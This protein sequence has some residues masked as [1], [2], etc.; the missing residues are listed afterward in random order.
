MPRK[1]LV[2]RVIALA[3]AVAGVLAG[4]A[5]ERPPIN[6][7]QANALA[8]SFFVGKLADPKDDPEFYMH[9]SVVDVMFGANSD[10]LISSAD[11]QAM[12]R[13]RWEITEKSLLGRL[14]YE[15]VQ[16]S[17]KKGLRATADGQIVAAYTIEKHFDIRNDYNS[18]TGEEVNVVVENDTD[19]PWHQREHFRVDWSKNLIS[20]AYTLDT[21]AQIGI[22]YAV[23]WEPL[24]YY[25]TDPASP[26]APVFSKGEGYFDI[27]NKVLAKPGI[28]DSEWGK[29]PACWLIG[30]FPEQSCNP[31]EVKL[32]TSFLQVRDSDYEPI[33]WDGERMDIAG[34]FTQDRFGFEKGYG[35][36][37]DKWHRFA[38]RWNL[39]QKSHA[40]TVCGID[41]PLGASVHR[42]ADGDGTEDECA[43]V[44]HGSRCDEF[45]Q[46]CTIP[47][48]DRTIKTLPWYVNPGFPAEL[49][50]GTRTTLA[51]WNDAVRVGLLAGR[52]AE[53]RRTAAGNCETTHGW[54]QPWADDFV[55]PVGN[56]PAQIP[57]VFVL[58]HNPVVAGDDPACGKAGLAPRLGDLRY[59]FLNNIA[60]PQ[61]QSPWGIMVDA[62]DPLSGEKISGSVNIWGARTDHAA[63]QL[64]DLLMLQQGLLDPKDYVKGKNVASWV[65]QL[66]DGGASAH[67]GRPM[68]QAE[69]Q[70]HMQAFDAKAL[71]PFI[72][73]LPTPAAQP[74]GKPVNPHLAH[75]KRL[76][77]LANA[78]RLGPGNGALGERLRRLK[79]SGV[80]AQMISPE[81]AQLAGF[82]PKA[83]ATADTVKQAS[84]FG[85][86]NPAMRKALHRQG[87]LTRAHNGSCRLDR[88]DVEPDNLVGLGAVAKKLFGTPD[89]KDPKAIAAWRK[90]IYDWARVEYTK[91]VLAHE[92]GHSMGLRHNFAASFDALNY[93]A[94][95][96]QLRTR[97]GSVTQAC[98]DGTTDG[99]NCI[100]PRWRDPISTEELENN[101][102]IYATTSVMDYPGDTAQDT[103]LLGKYDRAAMRLV[104]GNVVDVWAAPN[105]SVKGKGA[106][107]NRALKLTAFASNPGLTGVYQ[108]PSGDSKNPY[109]NLHYSRYQ[110][111]FSLL[112][113]CAPSSTP[114]AVLGQK[115][116]EQPLD[117]VDYRDIQH[118]VEDPDYAQFSWGSTPR[119][120]DAGGRV[121]RGY[122]FQSDEYADAGNVTTFTDDAGA[123]AFEIVRFL[124]SQYELRYVLDN[125]RRNRT[126][127]NS[128]SVVARV[129]SR[130]LD[131]IQSIAK[132]F[133]FAALL[134]GDPT[135]PS[136]KL[137]T[138]GAYGPLALASSTAFELFARMLTRPEPGYYCSSKDCYFVHQPAGVTG[139]VYGAD[140]DALPDVYGYNFNVPLGDGRFVHNDFD[141]TQGYWWGDYQTQV[142]AYYDKV[143]ATYYLGEAF[144]SFISNSKEDFIDGRYKNVN[145]AT[146]YPEQVRRLYNA[147]LTGDFDTFAPHAAG[148]DTAANN[149][150][151]SKVLYPDWLNSKEVPALPAKTKLVDPSYGWNERIYAM[152]WGTMFFTTNWS[153][154]FVN[155]ARLAVLPS[156][157]PDWKPSEIRT[158][159]DPKSGMT[160][161]ARSTGSE[162]IQGQPREKSAGARMVE[163][164]NRLLVFAYL[165]ERDANG[166]PVTDAQGAPI[167]VLDANG[168]PQL[169]PAHPG[170]G[171]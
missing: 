101:I 114:G 135:Q 145:F 56:G 27:T 26:D 93:D 109:L 31:T 132:T 78:G 52:L 19:R 74:S 40:S 68:A 87:L 166:A 43:A 83:P 92:L 64:A 72:G 112:Q 165:V 23:E 118:F 148:L 69:L 100:G 63:A 9:V 85:L 137:L 104:Y 54:P 75:K 73:D 1:S 32:R 84:P 14:R 111:E 18:T 125:F 134:D 162:L 3:A 115:C 113:D 55:P 128:D 140:L 98:A 155:Q 5:E 49:F 106:G 159:S 120:V 77:A 161:R 143:W 131:P 65:A 58:C 60:D 149:P 142:G 44:G 47:L 88:Q 41:T 144:D 91:G 158:F 4:C 107:K 76:E 66:K 133:A 121:R 129:Q 169:D 90:K 53:C 61:T 94:G 48:R 89:P 119:A 152:V 108:F 21:L 151:A 12:T 156:E 139:T 70:R 116:A 71:L 33:D 141:Y 46:K 123:D 164:A 150:A 62:E 35:V 117:V 153:Y 25:V 17:D 30:A 20:D 127:F 22:L 81:M 15:L 29:F 146:V 28:V 38:A 67:A 167:L 79:G 95:Y 57:N 59:N 96:W 82:N 42:D 36:V 51:A 124:E 10:G 147:L 110:Q 2:I 136:A 99:A 39:Y 171:G 50:E 138:D 11:G 37:D 103:R 157:M 163:W 7:V 34:L 160:Y 45:R 102:G 122:L 154:D 8:K 80:E 16:D 24:A 105:L 6:R 170:A 126:N 13:I 86:K 168:K 130:Y 97:N